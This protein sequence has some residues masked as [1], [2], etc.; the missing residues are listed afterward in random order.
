MLPT[1]IISSALLVLSIVTAGYTQ[2]FG[3]VRVV[4]RDPQ[5][6]AVANAQVVVRAKNS[7]WMQTTKSNGEG[8]ALIPA[9]PIGDYR[10]SVSAEGFATTTDRE[11]QVTSD[12]VTPLQL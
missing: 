12:K 11:I 8:I 9:V 1:K 4:I 2:I 6:L 7:E 10:I 3:T 5:N